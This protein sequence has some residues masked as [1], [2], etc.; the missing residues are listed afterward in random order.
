[1]TRP[2][3]SGEESQHAESFG[4]SCLPEDDTTEATFECTS[5][6]RPGTNH[7]IVSISRDPSTFFHGRNAPI[8]KET[9]TSG[10]GYSGNFSTRLSLTLLN[11]VMKGSILGLQPN[12]IVVDM[13]H[14]GTHALPLATLTQPPLCARY[15]DASGPYRRGTL[16][17]RTP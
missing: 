7:E 8:S 2:P 13:K 10:M 16:P 1:M 9:N 6:A 15:P 4:S 17:P 3:T 5:S 12:S 14:A 11:N